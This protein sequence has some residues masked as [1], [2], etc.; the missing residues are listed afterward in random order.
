M[1]TEPFVV[2]IHS[3]DGTVE[4]FACS[5]KSETAATARDFQRSHILS[6]PRIVVAGEYSKHVFVTSRVLRVDFIHPEITA[7]E[8][9]ADFSDIVELTQ[10]EFRG[11]AHLDE[12]EQMVRRE[13]CTPTGDLLVSFL[14]LRMAGGTSI[15]LMTEAPIKLPGESQSFMRFLLSNGA[16]Q[17]R[18]ACG[19]VGVI[20]LS[21]LVSY[22]VYP[23]VAEIPSD[24]L[25]AEPVPAAVS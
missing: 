16:L 24:A 19:G 1:A 7:F 18:L 12:P 2:R 4:S 3:I 8:F 15:F 17:I 23:G 10:E 5:A 13:G 14:E 25:L 21:N 6:Q 9:P 22:A 20:N 11:N